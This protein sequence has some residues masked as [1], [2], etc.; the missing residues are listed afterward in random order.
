MLIQR[1]SLMEPV[2]FQASPTM[3]PRPPG[4]SK[5]V[6]AHSPFQ[7]STAISFACLASYASLDPQN[8]FRDYGF[9]LPRVLD[10]DYF[11]LFTQHFV[12]LDI[13]HVLLNISSLSK[14]GPIFDKQW[15]LVGY[16]KLGTAA[17]LANLAT[18]YF[19]MNEK[20]YNHYSAGLSMMTCAVRGAIDGTR[21]ESVF[22]LVKDFII[23]EIFHE[24][25]GTLTDRNINHVAHLVGFVTGIAFGR[26]CPPK[27]AAQQSANR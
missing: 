1:N 14:T 3:P 4:P 18:S 12:H 21:N 11:R 17:T 20:S 22:S 10:G 15:G 24:V 8:A 7:Y 27:T 6:K 19:I 13:P 2:S 9:N 23:S 26:F 16:L 25:I 5:S